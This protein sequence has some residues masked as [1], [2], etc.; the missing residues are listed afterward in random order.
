MTLLGNII[1]A[2][3]PVK[4]RFLGWTLINMIADFI[5]KGNTVYKKKLLGAKRDAYLLPHGPQRKAISLTP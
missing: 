2:D 3:D 5:K 4:I 1:F